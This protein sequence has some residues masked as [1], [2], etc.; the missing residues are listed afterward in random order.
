MNHFLLKTDCP[1]IN[2]KVTVD[3][4]ISNVFFFQ[5][6]KKKD[7]VTPQKLLKTQ[8]LQELKEAQLL[9]GTNIKFLKNS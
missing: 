3:K 8:Q 1:L 5:E 6:K 2:I 7:I 4:T 9:L